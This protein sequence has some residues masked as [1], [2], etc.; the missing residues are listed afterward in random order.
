V[1]ADTSCSG[2]SSWQLLHCEAHIPIQRLKCC[3][4]FYAQPLGAS[5]IVVC[6]EERKYCL[7][8]RRNSA[9]E[10][11]NN[12]NHIGSTAA[13][14]H[15]AACSTSLSEFLQEITLFWGVCCKYFYRV[16]NAGENLKHDFF[17]FVYCCSFLSAGQ[18]RKM[19]RRL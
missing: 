6:A 16:K 12:A 3:L 18:I 7:L 17:F 15:A 2:V 10:E 13:K 9:S 11:P 14:A 19:T 8:F 4:L 5:A 1:D